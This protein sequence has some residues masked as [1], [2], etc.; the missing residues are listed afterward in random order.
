MPT[1]DSCMSVCR[2]VVVMGMRA[3]VA[4]KCFTAACGPSPVTLLLLCW[5]T[6]AGIFV[7]GYC[8]Y[9]YTARSDMSGFMQ[10]SFFFGYMAV[11]CFGFFLMLGTVGWRASLM[12]VRHIY[13]VRSFAMKRTQA[14]KPEHLYPCNIAFCSDSI[15]LCHA[16]DC[17]WGICDCACLWGVGHQVRVKKLKKSTRNS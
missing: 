4:C 11:V 13:K 16:V 1:S 10:G 9:Y 7:Y 17:M 12:F 14:D 5:F 6:H 15:K 3:M 2:Q 8:L